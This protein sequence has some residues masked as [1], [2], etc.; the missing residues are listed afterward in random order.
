MAD[1]PELTQEEREVIAA[2]AQRISAYTQLKR[3]VAGWTAE[4]A[5]QDKANRAVSRTVGA[6]VALA[7][8]AA[9]VY[10]LWR[11]GQVL[12]Q[13]ETPAM[14]TSRLIFW[15][16]AGMTAL[17]PV[18]F[19]GFSYAIRKFIPWLERP[20]IYAL[21][22]AGILFFIVAAGTIS[23]MDLRVL[24]AQTRGTRAK[25]ARAPHCGR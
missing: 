12:T 23:C 18:F 1:R 25:A 21:P 10:L 5:L 7:T 2:H 24:T 13:A 3:L 22:T 14:Q 17:F 15:Y 16:P 19:L 9:W 6:L 20:A 8:I 4:L 11:L